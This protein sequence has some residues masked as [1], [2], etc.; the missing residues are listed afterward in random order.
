MTLGR[1]LFYR[2]FPCHEPPL[3]MLVPFPHVVFPSLLLEVA[4]FAFSNSRCIRDY[5]SVLVSTLQ[6]ATISK[7]TSDISYWYCIVMEG[8]AQC[9]IDGGNTHYIC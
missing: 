1:A 8:V 6:D 2:G 4:F 3:W 7:T 9:R 5:L